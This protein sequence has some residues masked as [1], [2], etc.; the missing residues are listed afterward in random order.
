M[1]KWLIGLIA[2]GIILMM[3]MGIGIVVGRNGARDGD[4][5]GLEEKQIS[6]VKPE[7]TATPASKI[8]TISAV[9]DVMLGRT[10][11]EQMM[12]KNDWSWP[13]RETAARLAQADIT[14]GNLEAPIV[15][16]CMQHENR[17]V[18]CMNPEA[19]EG[20]TMAG[21]D[22]FTL[23][24]NHMLNYGQPGWQKRGNI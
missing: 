2:T 15:T 8:I 13:F 19:R 10:V 5:V 4:G 12:K 9:G 18:F 17:M 21:F 23:A 20:L 3:G 7:L 14:V 11:R 16:D 1:R 24:N 6:R 22:V